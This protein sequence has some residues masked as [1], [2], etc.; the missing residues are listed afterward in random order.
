[1]NIYKKAAQLKAI[2]QTNRGGVTVGGLFDLPLTTTK[3]GGVSL[4]GLYSE[5][6]AEKTEFNHNSYLGPAANSAEMAM[7][8]LK[9]ELLKDVMDTKIAAKEVAAKKADLAAKRKALLIETS[10]RIANAPAKM[11]DAEIAAELAK[12]EAELG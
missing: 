1:M 12:I 4:D 9:I 8:T 6:V 2:F 3:P 5:L 10:T 11:T 7:I